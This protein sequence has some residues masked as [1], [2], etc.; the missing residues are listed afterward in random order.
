MEKDC[1]NDYSE[2]E[3]LKILKEFWEGDI[4][5]VEEDEFVQS[6]NE[7]IEHPEKSDLIFYPPDNRDDSPEGVINELKRWYREQGKACFRA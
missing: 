7:I 3:F 2:Q 6:F 4:S 5:E 1:I